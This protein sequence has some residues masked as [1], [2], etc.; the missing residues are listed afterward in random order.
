MRWLFCNNSLFRTGVLVFCF[1]PVGKSAA[2][3]KLFIP[4]T[5]SGENISLQLQ[6]GVVQYFQGSMT[7][8]LGVNGQILGPTIVLRK[9][10][11]VTFNVLNRIGEPTTI[12]WHGMH[13]APKNDGGPHTVIDSGATWSPSFEVLDHAS[14]YWYHPHLH[15]KTHEQVQ[16]GIAGF[17]IVRDSAEMALNI[18]RKYGVDDFPLVIQTRGFD[19]NNQIITTQTAFDTTLMVNA[20]IKPFLSVPAQVV[21][22]RVLN[23]ASERVFNLGLSDNREFYQIG[24]DGG[25]LSKPL[26]LTRLTLAP[27]ERAELLVN[28]SGLSGS[29]ILLRNYGA[30]I[31]NAYYGARQPGMGAGQVIPNYSSN[32]LNGADYNILEMRV[33]SSTPKPVVGIPGTLVNV[34]S[35]PETNAVITRSLTFMSSTMGPG[36]INGPFMINNNHFD[37]N[38]INYRIPFNNVEIWELRNQT[39][40]AHP[41]HIHNVHFFVLSVNGVTPNASLQG[42]KDVVVVPGGNSTVR[43]IAHFTDFYDDSTP[44]MYHCHMLTHEDHGMMG[45]FIV[46]PP[47]REIVKHPVS[48]TV[49]PGEFAL[50]VMSVNDSST[51]TYQWQSN[52]GFGFQ[53]LQNAGQYSGTQSRTLKVSNVAAI[54]NNQLFRCKVKRNSCEQISENAAL[55]VQ[56]FGST[57]KHA[58]DIFSVYPNPAAVELYVNLNTKINA[59]KIIVMDASGR[60]VLSSTITQNSTLLNIE[61]LKEGLYF[62]RIYNNGLVQTQKFV[63]SR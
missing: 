16:K 24:S 60:Q 29:T 48:Q 30:E 41:F 20:T 42:R 33:V 46:E 32:P 15:E 1:W 25:L 9:H 12:H 35:I 59:G 62:V 31:P 23:G 63:I 28:L 17:I 52:V 10:Q 50:F 11:N 5:I 36:A 55:I 8:T 4:D 53:D 54:N 39:P 40:I 38:V 22:L 45:Q 27:G 43:F 7:Q 19:K 26:K 3:N 2:Q 47:C 18:P 44:Y 49:N 58:D 13:V 6:K 21:R 57:F 34:I 37:M 61:N 51:T 14:T 56:Q